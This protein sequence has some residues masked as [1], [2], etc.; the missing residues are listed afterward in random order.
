MNAEIAELDLGVRLD[1]R[2][3]ECLPAASRS[4]QIEVSQHHFH[5]T[6]FPAA[7]LRAECKQC[8]L[9]L[10]AEAEGGAIRGEI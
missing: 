5:K 6:I 8:V 9:P 1:D 7:Q 4:K 10:L 2:P 3:I